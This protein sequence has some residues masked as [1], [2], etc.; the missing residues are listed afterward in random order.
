[1]AE[2]KDE[3][4]QQNILDAELIP[5]EDQVKIG[6]SNFRIAL[7]KSQPDPIY[8]VCL[9]ILKHYN[10]FNAIIATAD[11]PEIY[12]QQL[13][14]TVS[15]DLTAKAHFF[16]INDQ[17]FELNADLL[18]NALRITPKDPDHPFTLPTL[19]KEII[20]FI[21]KLVP[22]G[23]VVPTGKDSSIVSTGSTKVIPAGNTILVLEPRI[24]VQRDDKSYE[25]YIA[26]GLIPEGHMAK[27]LDS[28]ARYSSF[29][30][31][32]LDKTKEP[33]ALLSVDSMLNWSDH[34][35][36]DVESGVAQ[37]YGMIAGAE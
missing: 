20:S 10:F 8:K 12:M 35:G 7:E 13:W 3:Q 36:E 33:K 23:S 22:A 1:M 16:K 18:R 24:A 21:N 30:L 37:V 5:I 2:S 9:E 34:E 29:K 14:H 28:K 31:K 26:L 15:Y 11:A 6:I 25:L 4:Q 27:Q 32:E 19:E 17:I